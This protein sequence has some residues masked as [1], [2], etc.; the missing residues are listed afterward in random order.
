MPSLSAF[1]AWS[2]DFSFARIQPAFMQPAPDPNG[3]EEQPFPSTASPTVNEQRLAFALVLASLLLFVIAAPF[4]RVKLAEL[5]AFIPIYQSALAIIDLV[6][7][8]LLFAQFSI[9]RLRA[10]LVLACGYLFTCGMVVVH[11]LTFPG[12]FSATG[13]LGAGPQTTAWLYAFWHLGFPIAVIAYARLKNEG[14]K[15]QRSPSTSALY[16]IGLVC[17]AVV[18]VTLL[19]T[20]GQSVLP[21][22]MRG[23]RYTPVLPVVVATICVLASVA[24]V[25]LW[26][27]PQRSTIDLWLMVTMCAWIFDIALSALLNGGRFDLGFYAGRL[28]GLMAATFVLVVLLTRTTGLYARLSRLLETEQIERRHEAA[29]RRRIFDTSLDLILIVD[30]QGNVLQASPSTETILGYDPVGMAGRSAIEFLY[31]EDLE[32]TRDIMRR[33][34]RGESTHSF[35]CRYVH[36]DGRIVP[37]SW[38]GVWSEPD[39]QHFFVGR[40]MTERVAL[41]QQLRQAQKMEAIG[42]LTGGIAHDFNNILAVIIGMTEL[43]AAAVAHDPKVSAMVKQID[44]SAERGALLVQRMLAFARKQPLEP[45][46]LEV[47][48]AVGRS[49]AMLERTLGE[50]INIQPVMGQD[51][52]PALVDQSQLEDAIVNLAVNARD[53]MPNGGRL[54]IETSNA[55]L[56]EEYAARHAEVT[57]GDYVAINVTDSGSGMPPDIIERVFEPFF[58]TKEVG[59]GTGLGLSMV[60]GFVK[61]SRGHVKIY[62]EVG[63]G[64]SIRLYFPRAMQQV[65]ALEVSATL[66]SALPAGRESILIVEDDAAVRSMA[67]GALESLGYSVRQASDGKGALSCLREEGPIDLLFTDMVMPNGMNGHDLITAARAMRPGLKCLLTSGYSEQ[68]IKASG[69]PSDVRLLNKPYRR[70]TLAS[71]IR[72]VLEDNS[73]GSISQ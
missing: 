26:R 72:S 2:Q 13:V 61:Q 43:T 60:Y 23:N 19:A 16:G 11:G 68:F 44:E 12:L 7:A 34:S 64:T 59:R 17:T 66:L 71:I 67:V 33:A 36:K 47:N 48:A 50:H 73:A 6:T 63:H 40:D 29:M 49:V 38:K 22:L 32:K 55:Q 57:A 35:D 30:R 41:E 10:L 24:L 51:L 31:P 9:L 52:W 58:T 37:L 46:I 39:Q 21:E 27:R 8:T 45:R 3:V 70:E 42:Q 18:T 4:A 65:P 54:V 1:R 5:W 69:S 56:D 15:V 53:A 62:S 25:E 14:A 28:Y 20:S